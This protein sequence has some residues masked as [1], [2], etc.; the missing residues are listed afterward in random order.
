MAEAQI[1]T[2][3]LGAVRQLVLNVLAS[4]SW[5]FVTVCLGFGFPVLLLLIVG[6]FRMIESCAV[7]WRLLGRVVEIEDASVVWWVVGLSSVLSGALRFGALVQ[8]WRK[9]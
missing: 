8:I 2:A 7:F 5:A 4:C 9:S 3:N 1:I 6:E